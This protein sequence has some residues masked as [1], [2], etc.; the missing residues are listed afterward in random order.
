[1]RETYTITASPVTGGLFS[2]NISVSFRPSKMILRQ[3]SLS[4]PDQAAAPTKRIMMLRCPGL[5]VNNPVLLHFPVNVVYSV[6]AGSDDLVDLSYSLIT[7]TYFDINNNV[8]GTINFIISNINGIQFQDTDADPIDWTSSEVAL[9][10]EFT[11]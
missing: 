3:F 9:T 1:M 5:V 2:A 11:D 7:E 10:L 8:Q 4:I 6:S